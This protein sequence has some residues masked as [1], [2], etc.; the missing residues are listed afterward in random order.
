M[1]RFPRVLTVSI[2]LLALLA[3]ACVQSG[4]ARVQT[5]ASYQATPALNPEIQRALDK[6]GSDALARGAAPGFVVSVRQKGRTVYARGFGVRDIQGRRDVGVTT[7]FPVASI[8]KQFTA[9]AILMLVDA[10]QL[11][12]DAPIAD[13]LPGLPSGN[14]VTARHLLTHTSGYAEITE[15][16]N[17]DRLGV[18]E[19]LRQVL[20]MPLEF[21]PGTRWRYD[22]TGYLLLSRLVERISGQT[23]SAFLRTRIFE[24]LGMNDS[25][26]GWDNLPSASDLS[27]GYQR[28]A[29]GPFEPAALPDVDMMSGAGGISSTSSDMMRWASALQAGRLLSAGSQ[30]ILTKPFH[31]PDGSSTRYSGGL[32]HTNVSGHPALWH[33]GR[34]PGFSGML[35]MFPQ[36]D[37]TVF[38]YGN[39]DELQAN[40]MLIS[41]LPLF[42]P[43][44]AG[45]APLAPVDG[46]GL[47]GTLPAN[48]TAERA[49]QG[50]AWLD[51]AIGGT[52]DNRFL[53]ADLAA[54]LTPQSRDAI[55]RL[56]RLGARSYR[57]LQVVKGTPLITYT[58]EVRTASERLSYKI[59]FTADGV[60]GEVILRAAD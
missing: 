27:K 20:G 43:D 39:S 14:V 24:P 22:N 23:Y 58:Y 46:P 59:A 56:D 10:G 38:I 25:R 37:L 44:V 12:L 31:L 30:E 3:G 51:Q 54:K 13:Y 57:L 40:T 53:R 11:D 47:S 4:A 9:T 8:T 17:V 49:A 60:V 16:A 18:E 21:R 32:F 36:D 50:V 42:L 41:I 7:I 28:F 6:I 48:A 2:C 33:A 34:M 19:G 55:K 1:K 29:L 5:G 15:I 35:F 45:P 26:Y 52:I